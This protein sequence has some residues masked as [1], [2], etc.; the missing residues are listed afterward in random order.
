LY[1]DTACTLISDNVIVNQLFGVSSGLGMSALT[2]DW[3]EIAY[4]GSPLVVP[5]WAQVN[6]FVGF[7]FFY[8]FLVPILYY[9]N[10]R[11]TAALVN[12]AL[13]RRS[14]LSLQVWF[15]AYLPI[16]SAA[17]FDRFGQPYDV[18]QVLD[19]S[20]SFNVTAYEAYSP[21]YLTSTYA[22]VYSLAFALSTAVIVHTVI[23]HGKSIWD[24]L[25]KVRTEA[26][27][28]HAKLMKHYSEVPDWWYV[29]HTVLFVVLGILASEVG[30]PVVF[31]SPSEG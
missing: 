8:W 29:A 14:L 7:L 12:S 6:V 28:V 26:D 17:V 22:S 31:C 11:L 16:S 23:Y 5:W 21:L 10:V 15:F 2:F 24:K 3:G 20:Q 13:S 9:K 19:S 1:T 25:K 30:A 4:I 18:T 27:D